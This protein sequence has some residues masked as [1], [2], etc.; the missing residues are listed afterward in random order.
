MDVILS[1]SIKDIGNVGDVIKVKDG[2]ARNYLLPRN[3]AYPATAV[4]LR[5]IEK[6][7][8]KRLAQEEKQ[9]QEALAYS[10]RLSK[11]SC[12]VSVEVNDRD[13][14]YG[15]VSPIDIVKALEIEGITIDKKAV[16]LERSIEEL[17]IYEV[18]IIL[19]S[20]VTAKV[21]LWVAKK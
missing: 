10:E 12:T 3:L 11:V 15:S 19:H 2:F 16:V 8:A 9:L 1:Q 18:G 4:N 7:K 13:Q 17:G 14:L 5:R 21:R 6:E 20:Q